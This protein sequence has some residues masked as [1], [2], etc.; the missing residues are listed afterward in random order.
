[1]DVLEDGNCVAPWVLRAS[2]AVRDVDVGYGE[3]LRRCRNENLRGCEGGILG[4]IG[5][6]Y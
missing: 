3:H 1:M 5:R 2:V 6:L 4:W